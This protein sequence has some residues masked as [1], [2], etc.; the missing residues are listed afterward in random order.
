MRSDD[1]LP[2]RCDAVYCTINLLKYSEKLTAT[3]PKTEAV[4]RLISALIRVMA[5]QVVVILGEYF[6]LFQ[7]SCRGS[8]LIGEVN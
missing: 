7:S 4:D 8:A 3:T 1:Y 2:Q 5:F 6:E